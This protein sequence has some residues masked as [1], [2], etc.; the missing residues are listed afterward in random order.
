MDL[1]SLL[2][3]A[4]RAAVSAGK[5]IEKIYVSETYL[6]NISF[7]EDASPL[8]IADKKS[9]A[10]IAEVLGRTTVKHIVSEEREN[11]PYAERRLW[12]AF[13]MV[14]PLDGTKEFLRR[15]G[16]FTV[17][18]ALIEQGVPVMGVIYV[19]VSG[20]LYF[21]AKGIG[22][23][24][25]EVVRLPESF[26]ESALFAAALPLPLCVGEDPF[27]I[28]ASASFRDPQTDRFI[29]SI[30]AQHPAAEVRC[31]GSSLKLAQLA[32]GTVRVYP[33]LS[34]IHE[35]D[36]AAGVAIVRFAGAKVVHPYSGADLSFNKED[37]KA[38]IFVASREF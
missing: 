13:W 4:I 9:D 3:S 10:M 11:A 32:E 38:D 26:S 15:T 27:V 19:P 16:E 22:S 28:A 8:T 5:E 33:R 31:I 18:I 6:G 12:D 34:Q 29:A 1:R 30:M 37:L 2:I 25:V 17:N 36:I 20:L 24:R 23:F 7:K 14:D 35:W 21:G